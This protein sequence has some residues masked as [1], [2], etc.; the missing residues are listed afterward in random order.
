M[1]G[2]WV[3]YGVRCMCVLLGLD[4][5]GIIWQGFQWPVLSLILLLHL[6]NMHSR[7]IVKTFHTYYFTAILFV[8]YIDLITHPYLYSIR[9]KNVRL[10]MVWYRK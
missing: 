7:F 3:W 4:R 5:D 6:H 9:M 2:G 1:Q 10:Q 8:N